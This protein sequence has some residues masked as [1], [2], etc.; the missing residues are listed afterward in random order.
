MMT[1]PSRGRPKGP[2]PASSPLPPLRAA[3]HHPRG[4]R[5]GRYVMK[6]AVR[7]V[8][9]GVAWSMGGDPWVAP[10]LFTQSHHGRRKRPHE[11]H[12]PSHGGDA[13]VPSRLFSSPAPTDRYF[14]NRAA[15]RLRLVGAGVAWSMGG[16]PWVQY[17]SLKDLLQ[18]ARVQEDRADRQNRGT[19]PQ[20]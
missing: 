9:A 19:D 6:R 3:L 1:A 13:S 16:D 7:L 10:V 18:E 2:L 12:C 5:K 20:D 17:I 4:R 14:M 11:P 15:K 8:G